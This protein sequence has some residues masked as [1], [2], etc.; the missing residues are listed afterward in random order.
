MGYFRYREGVGGVKLGMGEER[1]QRGNKFLED[2]W[3]K[4]ASVAVRKIRFSRSRQ[5]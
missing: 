4:G 2:T 1:R 3:K 5:P